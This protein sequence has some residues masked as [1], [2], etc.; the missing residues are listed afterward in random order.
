[1]KYDDNTMWQ[2][3]IDCDSS[4]D[5]IFFYVVKTVGVYCRPSCKSKTPLRK[6]V[7]YYKTV[8]DAENDGFRPCKRCRPDLPNFE[9]ISELAEKTKKLIDDYYDKRK[10]LTIEM[11]QLGVSANHLSVIF[12]KQYGI[13][14][15]EYLNKI[16]IEHATA[17]LRYT[18]IPIIDIAMETGFDSLG[19]FY[20]FFRKN[21]GTTPRKYCLEHTGDKK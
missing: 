21:T 3:L 15:M 10:R 13:P 1:M 5:G 9:P 4:Y 16:R 14:P 7:K 20:A 11:K 12:K 17:L 6:N 8:K 18:D 19:A 2:A